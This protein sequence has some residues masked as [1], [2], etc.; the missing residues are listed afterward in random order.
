MYHSDYN[1]AC[2]V[3][4]FIGMGMGSGSNAVADERAVMDQY[5]YAHLAW[6]LY[7]AFSVLVVDIANPLFMSLMPGILGF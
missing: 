7:P 1:G 3:A 4:G 2:M 5:G 6:V